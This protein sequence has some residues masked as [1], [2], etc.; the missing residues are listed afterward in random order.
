MGQSGH[1][2][3]F[4]STIGWPSFHQ[5][6][7]SQRFIG[8]MNHAT[9]FPCNCCVSRRGNLAEFGALRTTL[10]CLQNFRNYQ[11]SK[12]PKKDAKK[13]FNCVNEPIIQSNKPYILYVLPPPE[14][15]LLLGC[16]NHLFKQMALEFPVIAEAWAKECHIF[17]VD[18]YRGTLGFQG[19]SC[20]KLISSVDKLRRL[21]NEYGINC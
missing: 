16:V 3:I 8:L 18:V 21:C 20:K 4:N 17:R 11:T 9:S 10:N 6:E 12:K 15:H 19:N 2:S 13:C 1:Q 7:I 5:L 14:L